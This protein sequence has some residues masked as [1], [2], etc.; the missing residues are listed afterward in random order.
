VS[1]VHNLCLTAFALADP[2]EHIADF[3]DALFFNA[4]KSQHSQP[5]VLAIG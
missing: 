3:F 2:H 1:R 4:A 5:P